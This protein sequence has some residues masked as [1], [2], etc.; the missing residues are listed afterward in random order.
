MAI[1]TAILTQ[2]PILH[3]RLWPAG[4]GKSFG[5]S[6]ISTRFWCETTCNHPTLT[7]AIAHQG[8]RGW[9]VGCTQLA[10][11]PNSIKYNISAKSSF[12][13]RLIYSR[14]AAFLDKAKSKATFIYYSNSLACAFQLLFSVSWLVVTSNGIVFTMC[15]LKES[16][17]C[18]SNFLKL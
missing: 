13:S 8:T 14:L 11:R 16:Q 9:L 3:Q 5:I 1:F 17:F 18:S 10:Q 15:F 6:R 2:S 12:P 7:D 4:H